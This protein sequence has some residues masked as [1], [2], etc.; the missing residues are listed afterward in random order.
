MA[1]QTLEI[2]CVQ[3]VE[4]VTDYLE[5]TLSEEEVAALEAHLELCE[6]CDAYVEQMRQT[7]AGLGA[8]PEPSGGPADLDALLSAFRE[9]HGSER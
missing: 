7:I 8:L 1:E 4:I 3:V 9:H 5:R 2:R 6:G